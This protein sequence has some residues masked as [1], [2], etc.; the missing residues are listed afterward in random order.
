M[1]NFSNANH[2]PTHI[3]VSSLYFP[4]DHTMCGM[5]VGLPWTSVIDLLPMAQFMGPMLNGADVLP[6]FCFPLHFAH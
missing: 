1:F 4:Q 3:L 2:R 5:E 6:V